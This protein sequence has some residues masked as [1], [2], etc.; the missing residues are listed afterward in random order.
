MRPTLGR[1]HGQRWRT[2]Q[3][4]REGGE[5]LAVDVARPGDL[6]DVGGRPEPHRGGRGRV[7]AGVEQPAH[8]VER[9]HLPSGHLV[10]DEPVEQRRRRHHDAEVA[11]DEGEVQVDLDTFVADQRDVLAVAP[12]PSGPER[13]RHPVEPGGFQRGDRPRVVVAADQHV[14]VAGDP[15]RRI[16]IVELRSGASL[17]HGVADTRRAEQFRRGDAGG[18]GGERAPQ[19]S[20]VHVDEPGS[21]LVGPAGECA[22]IERLQHEPAHPLVRHGVDEPVDVAVRHLAAIASGQRPRHH[23]GDVAVAWRRARSGRS[24]SA[25]RAAVLDPGDQ[26]AEF[27]FEAQAAGGLGDEEVVTVAALDRGAPQPVQV[28][29]AGL[30]DAAAGEGG[31]GEP[32]A[33]LGFGGLRARQRL[34]VGEVGRRRADVFADQLDRA[35]EFG[36]DL[37]G[38]GPVEQGVGVGVR[39]DR[40]EPGGGGIAQAR[41]AGRWRTP[42][43]RLAAVDEV[44]GRVEG[45]RD[46][47]LDQRRHHHVAEVVGAVVE[48]DH[49]GPLGQGRSPAVA[50]SSEHGGSGVEIDHR[51]VRRA[52]VRAAPGTRRR[53][54]RPR[55]RTRHPRGGR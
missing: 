32:A 51:V 43:K 29:R 10:G 15:Q 11:G 18:L 49:D 55:R 42:R 4:H 8:R 13:R 6:H 53:R 34:R 31:G 35:V 48:G 54:G 45:R 23:G 26:I 27:A 30:V 38:L 20:E 50:I 22:G 7:D 41:P 40:D 2:A 52:D 47:V 5:L 25:G 24:R 37:G 3:L 9:R 46:A 28:G 21:G 17:Q 12:L 33:D 44:G 19:R 1:D 14:D 39:A 16:G 36:A